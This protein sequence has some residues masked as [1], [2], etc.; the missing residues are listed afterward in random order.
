MSATARP[1]ASGPRSA[2]STAATAPGTSTGSTAC[3]ARTSLSAWRTSSPLR[4]GLRPG[5]R[6]GRQARPRRWCRRKPS[7]GRPTTLCRALS[8]SRSR[9]PPCACAGGPAAGTR[10]RAW[11]T[12]AG[13]A[14]TASSLP[15]GRRPQAMAES[16]TTCSTCWSGRRRR[17]TFGRRP[18][19]AP[20]S[21]GPP[22]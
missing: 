4:P 12:R 18:S 10:R 14:G 11:P 3:R 2:K 15:P 17:P 19:S 16:G 8:V 20:T 5:R 13:E 21:S 9:A 22:A 6:L 1:P 7:A